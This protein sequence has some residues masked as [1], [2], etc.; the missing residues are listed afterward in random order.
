MSDTILTPAEREKDPQ[1]E[2]AFTYHAPKEGQPFKYQD[3]RGMARSLA[4]TFKEHCPP[5]R[6]LALAY[7]KLEEAVMWAN[8]AIARNG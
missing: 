6:E 5:S 7:T 3:I 4:Y 2:K 1:I 8:S